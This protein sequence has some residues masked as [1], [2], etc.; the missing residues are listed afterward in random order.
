M[1]TTPSLDGISFVLARCL[2]FGVVEFDAEWIVVFFIAEHRYDLQVFA[3]V[4]VGLGGRGAWQD[5][6]AVG[7]GVW[8]MVG[9][10]VKKKI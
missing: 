3:K 7:V 9:G 8:R 1:N 10:G 4:C 6:G 2:V 5:V